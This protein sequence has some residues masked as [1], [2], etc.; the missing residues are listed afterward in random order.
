MTDHQ[1]ALPVPADK[2]QIGTAWH[3][4]DPGDLQIGRVATVIVADRALCLTRTEEGFRVLDNRCPHQGGPLGEGHIEQ[5]WVM[6]PWHGFE[7]DPVTGAPPDDYGD[8][9]SDRRTWRRFIRRVTH[10]RVRADPHG[11]DGRRDDR[12]GG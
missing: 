5:G 8:D 6:C 11:S 3:R 10:L 4:V 12:M 7:Y 9:V 2:R 1:G